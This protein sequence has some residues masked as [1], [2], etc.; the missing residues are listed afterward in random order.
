LR[1]RQE[2]LDTQKLSDPLVPGTAAP[3]R[4]PYAKP[5]L[6]RWGSM[7]ELTRGAEF[8]LDSDLDFTGS[9]GV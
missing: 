6:V 7:A 3:P 2:N 9:G 8:G 5:V 4:K 1:R